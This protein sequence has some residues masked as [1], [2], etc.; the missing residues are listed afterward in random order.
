MPREWYW[1][2]ISGETFEKSKLRKAEAGKKY[3]LSMGP[4]VS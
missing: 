3:H 4:Q 2:A 1:D